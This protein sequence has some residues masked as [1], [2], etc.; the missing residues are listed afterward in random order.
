MET[1]RPAT[2]S[3]AIR[4]DSAARVH[5]AARLGAGVTVGPYAI[6]HGNTEIGEGSEI[7]A[8]AIVGPHTRMGAGNIIH[9]F[10]CVGGDP[11]DL[12]HRGEE[13]WLVMGDR[14]TVREHATLNRGTRKGDGITRVGSDNLIMAG[15]HVAHDCVLGDGVILANNVLLA[16]HVI[17]ED[18]AILNGAAAV[19][20]FTTIGRLSY[21]GGLSRIV[22]D[23]PPFLI[24]EGHP[25]KVRKLN[26]VGLRRAGHPEEAIVALREAFRL[27]Y[28]SR[29]PQSEVLSELEAAPGLTGEVRELTAFL[30]RVEMSLRA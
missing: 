22:H 1:L 8:H 10:A 11:Q 28:R 13:T 5:P 26:V 2:E 23:V 24:V 9:S 27:L 25:S 7:R 29:R 3:A 4:V 30:R 19:Q 15:A 14:N 20:Q 17:V 12:S 21:V 6:V 18:R 16:G